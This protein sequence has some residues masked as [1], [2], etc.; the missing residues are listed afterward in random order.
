LFPQAERRLVKAARQGEGDAILV[1]LK[2]FDADDLNVNY[3]D[4]RG[5]EKNTFWRAGSSHWRELRSPL[6]LASLNNCSAAVVALVG[7]HADPLQRAAD[8]STPL[9]AAA[10]S[11][12]VK[13][14]LSA[15]LNAARDQGGGRN[16]A[17]QRIVDGNGQT[18]MHKAAAAGRA[19]TIKLLGQH[20]VALDVQDTT[21]SATPLHLAVEGDHLKAVTALIKLGASP[22]VQ[23]L[24]DY[25]TPLLVA[26][27]E[28]CKSDEGAI[29]TTRDS[30]LA[31]I[32][33]AGLELE[34]CL[35]NSRRAIHLCLQIKG[36]SACNAILKALLNAGANPNALLNDQT[37]LVLA[38]QH[39]AQNY[40]ATI[41]LLENGA[42]P[43]LTDD[44]GTTVIA[45]V[46]EGL[47][48]DLL[49]LYLEHSRNLDLNLRVHDSSYLLLAITQADDAKLDE[50]EKMAASLLAAPLTDHNMCDGKQTSPVLLAVAHGAINT[51]NKLVERGADVDI[52]D[53]DGTTAIYFACRHLTSPGPAREGLPRPKAAEARRAA[54]ILA[55]HSQA[56]FLPD[57]TGS[58]ALHYACRHSVPEFTS[59]LVERNVDVNVVDASGMTALHV[60]VDAENLHGIA[61]VGA[62]ANVNL[63]QENA[64][65]QTA[66]M[67]AAAKGSVEITEA[68]LAL[69]SKRYDFSATDAAGN[70]ALHL[71]LRLLSS[72]S[73]TSPTKIA[74]Q[75][76]A[77]D[78][79]ERADDLTGPTAVAVTLIGYMVASDLDP[80]DSEDVVPVWRATTASNLKVLDALVGHGATVD[81][82]AHVD[83]DGNFDSFQQD[84]PLTPLLYA[85]RFC[86]PLSITTTLIESASKDIDIKDGTGKTVL[87]YFVEQRRHKALGILLANTP[88]P[89]VHLP[90][91]QTGES[92]A[93]VSIRQDDGR[94]LDLLLKHNASLDEARPDDGLTPLLYAVS[95]D[96]SIDL[97]RVIVEY[98]STGIDA[99]DFDGC[100]A[101]LLA[102]GRKKWDVVNEIVMAN[103]APNFDIQHPETGHTA[104]HM[105][106]SADEGLILRKMVERGASLDL[107]SKDGRTVLL[108][109]LFANKS[110]ET[111]LFLVEMSTDIDARDGDGRTALNLACKLN[112]PAIVEGCLV[113]GAATDTQDTFAR[114]PVEYAL[115]NDAPDILR[116]LVEHGAS[117]EAPCEGYNTL[118]LAVLDQNKSAELLSVLLSHVTE[119]LDELFNGYT[120]AH[121]FAL[122]GDASNLQLILRRGADGT[123]MDAN[124]RTALVIAVQQSDLACVKVTTQYGALET[125]KWCPPGF[126]QPCRPFYFAAVLAELESDLRCDLITPLLDAG[127]DP[128]WAPGSKSV[129]LYDCVAQKQDVNLLAVLLRQPPATAPKLRLD[130]VDDETGE[131]ALG[132]AARLG[133]LTMANMLVSAGA[134]VEA[135]TSGATA[136]I[137]AM[138]GGHV[139]VVRALLPRSVNV[140]NVK[141]PTGG[142][143][144]F[145]LTAM[146]N[147]TALLTELLRV[148]RDKL[149]LDLDNAGGF[150]ALAVAARLNHESRGHGS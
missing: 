78:D 95:H 136:L 12:M 81:V 10:A 24:P 49:R 118:L 150:T 103:P 79:A 131:T 141:E 114:T 46:I 102:A 9:H 35:R 1:L 133:S 75:D 138:K 23:R 88:L 53:K 101:L 143:T 106:L 2:K 8:L 55:A 108:S 96:S 112:R 73:P 52:R 121:M 4:L 28:A 85:A 94:T 59:G 92:P 148:P 145:H 3:V 32:G 38:L 6:Y 63:P 68:L 14:A 111:V 90:F 132:A 30:A 26:L 146:R 77:D 42:N 58:Y 54:A 57:E 115:E 124:G 17:F 65:M 64:A 66:L 50:A 107:A 109:A 56:I 137:S 13:T 100:T 129:P 20:K 86:L 45:M 123:I 62:Q 97:T 144:I 87:H 122:R 98:T 43:N 19:E 105:A 127:A 33:I 16:A 29:A 110:E 83:V 36:S 119:G 70:H 71:C 25:A 93:F 44:A 130:H 134:N 139:E 135:T 41:A 149:D 15:M 11:E 80:A 5:R 128:N 91:P 117:L 69:D 82:L 72:M 74:E 21:S 39:Q 113:R 48:V 61:T 120:A 89:D 22:N 142:N 51:L 60:A 67:Q 31:L 104:T 34:A 125:E 37:P 76:M 147:D 126:A 7:R 47:H 99:R 18:L 40:S 140:L 27:L 116:L 84:A